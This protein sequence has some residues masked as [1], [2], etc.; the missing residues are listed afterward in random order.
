MSVSRLLPIPVIVSCLG[1]LAAAKGP[2]Q[3]TPLGHPEPQSA[4]K[5]TAEKF[6]AAVTRKDLNALVEL[7][8]PASPALPAFKQQMQQLFSAYDRIEI[9]NIAISNV[10]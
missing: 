4:L 2:F 3:Q 5:E 10:A 9:K 6:C 8:S 7:W 1:L